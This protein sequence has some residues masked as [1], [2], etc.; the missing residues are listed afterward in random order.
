VRRTAGARLH[1]DDAPHPC[2][3]PCGFTC[4]IEQVFGTAMKLLGR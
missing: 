4:T 1:L 2:H 3:C